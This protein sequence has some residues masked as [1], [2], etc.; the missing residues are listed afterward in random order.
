MTTINEDTGR[1]IWSTESKYYLLRLIKENIVII[2]PDVSADTMN[3]KELAWKNIE[4][5]FA[6]DGMTCQLGKLKRLWKR[7]KDTARQNILRYSD[8]KK[9]GMAN[10]KEPT[11]LDI[12]VAELIAHRNNSKR[13]IPHRVSNP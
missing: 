12:A 9:R 10:I 8:L 3:K 2:S 11:E 13:I 4:E 7:M 1:I 5:S 6:A